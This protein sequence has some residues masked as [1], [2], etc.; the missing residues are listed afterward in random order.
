MVDFITDKLV[1]PK[2]HIKIKGFGGPK[3]VIIIL[4]Y[5]QD[6]QVRERRLFSR[7]VFRDRNYLYISRITKHRVN[8]SI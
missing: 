1:I 5:G 4:V 8:I 2:L 6:F 3:S 7:I